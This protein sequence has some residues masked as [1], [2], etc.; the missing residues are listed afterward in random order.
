M[1]LNEGTWS[2]P[3]NIIDLYN[4]NNIKMKKVKDLTDEDLSLLY[5]VCGNDDFFDKLDLYPRENIWKLITIYFEE[6]N[7]L[8]WGSNF[9]KLKYYINYG[10]A[11]ENQYQCF[12]SLFN[13]V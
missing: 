5:K 1:K 7:N 13:E 9:F 6:A 12:K 10:W 8:E 3:N 4:L 11:F 2:T